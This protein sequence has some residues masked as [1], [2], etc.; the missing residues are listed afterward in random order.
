MGWDTV[1]G[2]GGRYYLE[3]NW[4]FTG[5]MEMIASAAPRALPVARASPDAHGELPGTAAVLA[6][7][8]R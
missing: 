7:A 6:L 5:R 2:R 8:A 3:V 1:E 4:S